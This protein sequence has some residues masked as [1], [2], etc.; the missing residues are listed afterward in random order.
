MLSLF[1][2][3]QKRPRLLNT[4][5]LLSLQ[6]T[7]LSPPQ[8]A[9]ALRRKSRILARSPDTAPSL[10]QGRF[11]FFTAPLLHPPRHES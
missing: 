11:P 8:E 6:Q 9:S 2:F 5:S 4:R 1:H 3:L 10:S 7:Q